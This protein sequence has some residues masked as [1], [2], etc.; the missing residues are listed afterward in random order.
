MNAAEHIVQSFFWHAKSERK[1]KGRRYL[2]ISNVIA[3]NNREIDILAMSGDGQDKL[4]VE[5]HVDVNWPTTGWYTEYIK[6]TIHD[7]MLKDDHTRKLIREQVG[8]ED[9]SYRKIFV[10]WSN[11]FPDIEVLR[12]D[13]KDDTVD[14][15]SITDLLQDMLD[16]AGT[17]NYQDDILRLM[18]MLSSML[19]MGAALRDKNCKPI[20]P[21]VNTITP[22]ICVDTMAALAKKHQERSGKKTVTDAHVLS[23]VDEILR[24]AHED[25]S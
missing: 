23:A 19:C 4:R 13:L 21:S 11:P 8:W 10:V 9:D 16:S 15:W 7:K 18:S 6:K 17:S 2:T 1:P 3:G 22:K 24:L 14:C 12:T 25:N 5:C 20:S